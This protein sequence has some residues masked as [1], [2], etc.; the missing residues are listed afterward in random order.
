MTDQ[1]ILRLSLRKKFSDYLKQL[2]ND[3]Q[4]E[5]LNELQIY[6]MLQYLGIDPDVYEDFVDD[7][8]RRYT[9]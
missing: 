8:R 4:D 9:R 6:N 5:G 1:V 2:Y 3:M 7:Y